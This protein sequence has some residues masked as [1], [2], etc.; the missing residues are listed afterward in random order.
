MS[1]D[2]LRDRFERVDQDGNGKIDEPEFARLL[3][4]LGVGYD[5]AQIRAA[6]AA[7]DADQSGHIELE[8][9]RSWWTDR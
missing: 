2:P 6:F 4:D 1:T 9:F 3:D 8:E 5:D 7:I